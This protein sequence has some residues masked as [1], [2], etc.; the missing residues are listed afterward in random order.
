MRASLIIFISILIY[1]TTGCT[2][3]LSIKFPKEDS[4]LV[5]NCLLIDG[6]P[7]IAQVSHTESITSG[8]SMFVNN[9]VVE[10]WEGDT[11]IKILTNTIEGTYVSD[12][13]AKEGKRYI[14]K[15]SADGYVKVEGTDSVPYKTEIIDAKS[16]WGAHP[17][18]EAGELRYYDDYSL[19]FKDDPLHTNYYEVLFL[20]QLKY[21][22][23]TTIL[24]FASVCRIPDPVIE[25]EGLTNYFPEAYDFSDQHNNGKEFTVSMSFS[26]GI[27]SLFTK[28]LIKAPEGYYTLLRSISKEYYNF[29]KS[30]YVHRYNQQIRTSFD[31]MI[32]EG[33]TGDPVPLYTNVK[34]GYGIVAAYSQTYFKTE[35]TDNSKK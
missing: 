29:K 13:Y 30:W 17:Y 33:L 6:E 3:E 27:S 4:K 14:L 18:I 8:E 22:D 35:Y 5:L 23:S 2:K 1:F 7:I 16:G 15:A 12:I 25:I 19:V 21:S 28:P 20:N 9:A 26:G 34:N 10:L 24:S 11:L 32:Y 31:E